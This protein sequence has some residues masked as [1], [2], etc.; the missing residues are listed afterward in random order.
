MSPL[1]LG[2]GR[3]MPIH[4]W[5][6]VVAGNFHDFHQ[7]WIIAI[8][9]RLNRDV[10][11]RG[12]YAMAEQVAKGPVPDV[13]TLERQDEWFSESS[14]RPSGAMT[15]TAHPPQVRFR[16]EI[17]AQLYARRADRIAIHHVNGDRIV[18]YVE[19]VSPG[20]KH[21]ARSVEQFQQK[22]AEAIDRGCHVLVV[23]VLPPG[24]HDPAGMHAAFWKSHYE[25]A[26]GV[27]PDEPFGVSSYCADLA[28]IGYFEPVGLGKPLPSMPLFLTVDDYVIVPLEETYMAAWE[29]VPDRWK[30]VLEAAE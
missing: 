10:L 1:R 23:D 25:S 24:R 9:H 29:D 8:K 11:P 22:L 15:V 5:K 3:K 27:S 18:A 7:T 4:D 21:S 26:F 12:Y 20:N 19:I 28:P 2:K 6:R 13:L 14:P 16:E 30:A 17:D